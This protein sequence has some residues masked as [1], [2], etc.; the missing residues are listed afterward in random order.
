[1]QHAAEKQTAEDAK[2]RLE[3]ERQEKTTMALDHAEALRVHTQLR[4]SLTG[5]LV[6]VLLSGNSGLCTAQMEAKLLR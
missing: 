5:I 2:A 4:S 1:M 3:K 6:K